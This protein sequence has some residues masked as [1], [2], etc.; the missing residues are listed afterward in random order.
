MEQLKT[1][2]EN[3]HLSFTSTAGATAPQPMTLLNAN[4]EGR[5]L[6]S[7]ERLIIDDLQGNLSTGQADI[8]A[9]STSNVSTLIGSFNAAAGSEIDTKEGISLPVGVIPWVAPVGAGSTA[10][11]RVTGNGRI[12]EGTTQGVRPSWQAPLQGR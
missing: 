11:M 3:V 5:T 4:M 10:V 7:F 8:I 12:V 9:G 1:I 6:L 2:G